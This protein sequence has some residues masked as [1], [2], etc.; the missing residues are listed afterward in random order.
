MLFFK[1]QET[2]TAVDLFEKLI[3]RGAD[4]NYI[5]P[6][7]FFSIGCSRENKERRK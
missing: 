4:V 3:V 7:G 1:E 6:M 2:P 5:E